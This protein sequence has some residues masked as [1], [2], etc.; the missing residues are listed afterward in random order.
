MATKKNST[1]TEWHTRGMSRNA[2]TLFEVAI[3]LAILA[4]GVV[5]TLLIFPVGLKSQQMA[6]YRLY[7]CAKAEEMIEAF[8][9]A[10]NCNTA[11]DAEG[12][13]PWEVPVSYRNMAQ[14]LESRLANPQF[15]IMPLPLDIARRIDS[16]GAEMEQILADGGYVYYSQ[17][18]ATTGVIEMALDDVVATESQRLVIGVSGY[19]QN[20]AIPMFPWKSW[21]YYYPYPSPP[22]HGIHLHN[23]FLDA[24]SHPEILTYTW[25]A[26]Q[27]QQYGWDWT[28]DPDIAVVFSA[29]DGAGLRYGYQPYAY[30]GA[31]DAAGAARYVQAALWYCAKKGLPTTFWEPATMLTPIADFT[32]GGA[33]P[34]WQQVDAMRFLAHAAATLTRWHDRD[35]LGGQPSTGPGVAIASAT[36]AGAPS[37]AT[38]ITHDRI[39]WYHESCMNLIMRFV[40]CYPYD[41]AVPRPLQRASMMDCPLLEY[42]L[43]SPPRAGVISGSSVSAEQWRPIA[44]Q[45]IAN[46]GRSF[47][48]PNIAIA[49]YA[50]TQPDVVPNAMWGR[51]DHFTLTQSFAAAERCRQLVF[52]SVDWMAYED[53]ETAPSAP[54]D[55]SKYVFTAPMTS[56]PQFVPD[57]TDFL[58]WSDPSLFV[59]RNPEKNLLFVNDPMTVGFGGNVWPLMMKNS[60]DSGPGSGLDNGVQDMRARMAF[61]GRFGADRN[62]N[63]R[64]D[65]GSVSPSTRMRAN[66]VGRFNFYDSRVSHTIR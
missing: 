49:P 58:V 17:P 35:A 47:Q 15:G 24:G 66:L 53:F 57:R 30:G 22:A 33:V 45:P 10:H 1:S 60:F 25:P 9:A 28:N 27:Y 39:V 29:T 42:D 7:A 40:S 62:F 14:D 46:L 56:R 5:S 36:L 20:N 63:K 61:S 64:L 8:N 2:F 51:P 18:M 21:P 13:D 50:P 32:Q 54:V 37:P 55:A 38:A 34:A 59:Y 52:W 6:R 3:S 48:Y 19:A 41:W 26:G 12:T 44:S 65:R 43:H 11:M 31:T 16:P 4:F 23:E